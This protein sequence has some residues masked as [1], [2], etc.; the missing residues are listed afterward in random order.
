MILEDDGGGGGWAVEFAAGDDD[1]A[2][3]GGFEAGDHLKEGGLAAAGKAEEA[4]ELAF[5]AGDVDAAEGFDGTGFGGVGLAD[6]Y[7]LDET[8]SCGDE[9]FLPAADPG[10][11]EADGLVAGEADGADDDDAGEDEFGSEGHLR[12]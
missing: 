1:L 2:G 3:G 11:E 10:A 12:V 6:A 8:T 7:A 9:A 4:D 5:G